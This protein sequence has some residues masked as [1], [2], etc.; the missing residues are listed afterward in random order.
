MAELTTRYTQL[1]RICRRR[2]CSRE[3]A[4]ELVQEAYLRLIEYR[5]SAKVKNADS[6]LRR[7]VINLSIN[8]FH[9]TLS[10]PYA[11]ASIDELEGRETLIDPA[12]GPERALLAEQDLDE[13]V[14]RLSAASERVCRIF[15]AQRM[16]YS[17]EEIG[18]A[19]GIMP[20]TV[21]RHVA[22]ATSTLREMM[23]AAF[24][25]GRPD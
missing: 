2:G 22:S 15:I 21:E 13:V 10:S 23:P 9:R 8:Y 14:A 18:T 3:D 16:G 4:R 7:I 5:R 24:T 1:I 6:L 20:R 19:F 17:Y 11:F 25:G 12:P